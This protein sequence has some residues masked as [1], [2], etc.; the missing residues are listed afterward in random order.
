MTIEECVPSD[1]GKL[2]EYLRAVG[3][4]SDNLSFGAEGIG[5][6]IEAEEEYIRAMTQSENGIL[7]VARDGR[8]IVGDVSISRMARRMSHRGELG[9]AVRCEYQNR[10]I[11][12]RLMAEA[13]KRAREYG[14]DL[15]EL[16]LRADNAAARRLY[17]KFGFVKFGTHPAFF[18][19]DGEDIP[20]DYM[21][22]RL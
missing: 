18:K 7:L 13:L 14:F 19:L 20:F 10:G 17:E 21:Y 4:E 6:S 16:E 12:S 9:I 1:A 5:C 11:G 2:L 15:I 8:E 3:G 22:L